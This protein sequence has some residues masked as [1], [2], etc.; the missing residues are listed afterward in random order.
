[1][2]HTDSGASSGLNAAIC[3]MPRDKTPL[4]QKIAQQASISFKDCLSEDNGDHKPLPDQHEQLLS[5]V[6]AL[7]AADLKLAPRKSSDRPGT[8]GAQKPPVTYMHICET[9]VFS[10]GVFLLR[11]GASIPLHDHPGMNGMLKVVSV[12]HDTGLHLSTCRAI[13]HR[14]FYCILMFSTGGQSFGGVNI[15][16]Q[17]W[18]RG[19]YRE[20]REVREKYDRGERG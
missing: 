10:M 9:P 8:D 15:F 11:A 5:L 18:G 7:R 14:P 3:R 13:I 17:T 6:N 4:I 16:L 20:K 12:T 19:W 1:M 2:A